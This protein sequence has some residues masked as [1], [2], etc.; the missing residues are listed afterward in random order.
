MEMWKNTHGNFGCEFLGEK[1][2]N[3]VFD[4][5]VEGQVIRGEKGEERSF[6]K[7]DRKMTGEKTKQNTMNYF[8]KEGRTKD[9]ENSEL[10]FL[11]SG[12]QI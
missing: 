6:S 1:N 3:M 12:R 4:V 2:R 9:I 11:K 10:N 7:T 8:R 5:Q